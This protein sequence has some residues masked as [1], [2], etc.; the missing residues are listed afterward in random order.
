MFGKGGAA[1]HSNTYYY[2]ASFDDATAVHTYTKHLCVH[3]SYRAYHE[4][5]AV[6]PYGCFFAP[7]CGSLHQAPLWPRVDY[8][9]H[10]G[11]D[12]NIARISYS[13][14]RCIMLPATL[15]GPT[16]RDQYITDHRTDDRFSLHD[17]DHSD[18]VY[19]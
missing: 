3:S 4:T 17:V 11:S 9:P 6:P 18:D 16:K 1:D 14:P 5:K 7:D 10:L 8:N 2:L 12:W 19:S 15:K 13:R